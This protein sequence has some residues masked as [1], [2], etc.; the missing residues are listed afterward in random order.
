MSKVRSSNFELMRIISM[1]LIILWH[2][3]MHGHMIENSTNEAITIFLKFIM[4]IIIIHVNS[5]VILMGFFQSKSS[6][7]LA[8][9][10]RLVFQVMFYVILMFFVS[11]KMGWIEKIDIALYIDNF[12]PSSIGFYWFIASYIIVYILSD[13]L[14]IIIERIN[15]NEFKRILIVL[16]ILLS[17]I[18]YITGFKFFKND[19]L[20]FY[21]FIFLYLVGA[22]IRIY[23]I[24]K[25][26]YLKRMSKNGYRMFLIFIFLSMAFL[27]FLINGFA[28]RID[29]LNGVFSYLSFKILKSE[30][31]YFVPFVIVQSIAYFELFRTFDFKNRLINYLSSCMFGIYLFHE[32]PYV[33]T[34]IYNFLRIDIGGFDSYK[35]LLRMFLIVFV[36]FIC[37]LL[38]EIVRK[39]IVKILSKLKIFN[40]LNNVIKNF[41]NS[42]KTKI[43]W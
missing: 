12:M 7:E 19:G 5:F 18:P 15:K 10:F 3:I 43:N 38:V 42:F 25:S 39:L 40:S 33:Q 34:H 17:I 26:Y 22:Y 21:S 8:K 2:V 6:F 35:M 4:S 36:I 30:Y 27:N 9:L 11:I 24:D 23:P 41:I 20:N 31:T 37:G 32:F 16:F 13:F 1:I 14:N 28:Y 29:G